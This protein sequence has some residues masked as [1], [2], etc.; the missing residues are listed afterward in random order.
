[1]ESSARSGP[2]GR[3]APRRRP[4]LS[5]DVAVHV[6]NLIMSGGVR[7]GDFI[8][9]DETAADLGVSVTPVRE[10]LLTL[11]GEG[12]VELVPHRGYVVAPLS[13]ADIDDLFW[14][15]G[16]IAEKLARRAATAITPDAL[17]ELI[18]INAQFAD[19]V[20]V[21]DAARIEHLEFTFHRTLNRV[22]DA[23]KLAWFLHNT[24]RYTPVQFYSSDRDWGLEAVAAHD[25]IL[26]AL[27]SSDAEAA[28][29][30]TARHFTDGAR[31]LVRH[32]DRMGIW[33]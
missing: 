19:A 4:Q 14:L 21:G 23:R 7:P 1:M 6:R 8:R 17:T 2:P 9:L 26:E 28:G 24:T 11:R 15:Q 31:R 18:D 16:R 20:R 12:L 3:R 25:R 10:A 33:S 22:A 30:E 27:R 13:R 5:D 29:F 32:L